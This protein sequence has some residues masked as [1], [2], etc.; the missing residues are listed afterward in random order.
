MVS[1]IGLGCWQF[2]KAGGFIGKFW[3]KLSSD[4]EREI[5]SVS[6]NGGVNWFDTAE[7]YGLGKSEQALAAALAGVGAKPGEVMIATKWLPIGRFAGSI[8]RTIARRLDCLAPYPIDLYQIHFPAS[9]SPIPAQ[10]RAMAKLAKSGKIRYVGVSNFSAAQMRLA[11]RVLAEEGI[12][13]VSNQVLYSLLKRDIERNGVLE[14]AQELGISL[15]AYS[16]LAQGV[17]TGRFHEDPASFAGLSRMRTMSMRSERARLPR[18]RALIDEL[19][20][21]ASGRGVTPAEVAL[22]WTVTFHG[23]TIVAIPGASKVSQAEHNAH[24]MSF[25]L[26]TDE[27]ERIDELS[28]Q[29]VGLRAVNAGRAQ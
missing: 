16:P 10:L 9:F 11:Y 8:G 4:T 23:G 27:L 26:S 12:A 15:I 29:V 7:A 13:L 20:R 19:R 3:A 5:V 22:N 14:T 1:P 24:A 25:T 2:S 18:T 17:L 21:I 6:R 28:R